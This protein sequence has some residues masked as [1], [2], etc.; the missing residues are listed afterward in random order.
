MVFKANT[1]NKC[2]LLA[3]VALRTGEV[4]LFRRFHNAPTDH[5]Q[6]TQTRRDKKTR[7]ERGLT[8]PMLSSSRSN[9]H[10]SSIN[11]VFLPP[12]KATQRHSHATRAKPDGSLREKHTPNHPI[13][14]SSCRIDTRLP[15]STVQNHARPS[16]KVWAGICGCALVSRGT[17][18]FGVH[19]SAGFPCYSSTAGHET[20]VL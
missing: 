9:L 11:A 14:E 16:T 7:R 12:P 6:A 4:G 19:I 2:N 17:A 18:L 1:S 20:C 10:S 3:S 5:R 13:I 8:A 15:A